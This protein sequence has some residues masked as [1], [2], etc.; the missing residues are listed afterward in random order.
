MIN[1][2]YFW[3]SHISNFF[4][5]LNSLLHTEY[6]T[7]MSISTIYVLMSVFL[8]NCNP[9]NLLIFF[10]LTL[11]R[12]TCQYIFL[13]NCYYFAF[14]PVL[15]YCKHSII[16]SPFYL[17]SR[18]AIRSSGSSKPTDK[19][20]KSSVIPNCSRSGLGMAA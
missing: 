20:I 11:H 9:I 14:A 13:L 12:K 5:H 4:I 10:H 19:R 2:L 8:I 6:H 7:K 17:S 15:L 18:S 1:I 16:L 3:T